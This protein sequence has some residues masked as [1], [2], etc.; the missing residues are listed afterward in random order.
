MYCIKVFAGS[1]LYH[2]IRGQN[3]K[4]TLGFISICTLSRQ[5]KTKTDRYIRRPSIA[6]GGIV[7]YTHMGNNKTSTRFSFQT[8]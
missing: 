2:I 6:D 3:R 5:R 8:L 1:I 7:A 4:D